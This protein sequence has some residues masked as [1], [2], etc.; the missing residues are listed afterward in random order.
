MSKIPK[1]IPLR[2][3]NGCGESKPK[4]QLCR[5]VRSPDGQVSIDPTGKAAGRG[6]YVCKNSDCLKKAKKTNRLSRS[7]GCEVSEDIMAVLTEQ[8]TAEQNKNEDDQRNS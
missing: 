7:L 5:V 6:A 2:R 8:I 4:Q 1:K 3:C